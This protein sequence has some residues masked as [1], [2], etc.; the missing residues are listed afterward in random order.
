[1]VAQEK[2]RLN[3]G[4]LNF[5]ELKYLSGDCEER[6]GLAAWGYKHPKCKNRF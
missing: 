1:L 6:D 4:I 3:W 2:R 5:K